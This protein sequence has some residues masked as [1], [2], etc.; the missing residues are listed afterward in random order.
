MPLIGIGDA[1]GL[2]AEL[3]RHPRGLPEVGPALSEVDEL[4]EA[5]G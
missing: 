5:R 1:M 4:A 2:M 3:P